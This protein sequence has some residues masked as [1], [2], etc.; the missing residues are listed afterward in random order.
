MVSLENGEKLGQGKEKAILAV[1][2]NLEL[3]EELKNKVMGIEGYGAV[4]EDS[5]IEDESK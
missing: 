1:K 5:L 3:Q 2:E 4:L